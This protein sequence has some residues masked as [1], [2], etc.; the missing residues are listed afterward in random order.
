MNT[1]WQLTD[2]YS[3]PTDPKLEQDWQAADELIKHLVESKGQIGQFDSNALLKLIVSWEA[4]QLNLHRI[5]LYA[6]LLEAT[7]IGIAEVTRFKK[8]VEERLVAKTNQIIFIETELA[9][10]TPKQWATHRAAVEL[11]PYNKLLEMLSKQAQ[12]T[13]SEEAETILSEKGQTSGQALTH[14]YSVTTDTLEFDWDGQIVTLE[15]VMAKFHAS[16]PA[17]RKQ[18]AMVLHSGLLTNK[19]TTPPILNALIQDKAIDDRLRHYEYPEQARLMNDDVERPAVES[20][21]QAVGQSYNLV[22]R[23]YGLKKKI[24]GLDQLYWWDRYAPLPQAETKIEKETAL[25]MVKDAFTQFSP[26]MAAITDRMVTEKHI[27]WLPS[28]TKRGGAFCAFGDPKTYPYVL[29]NYTD[30]PRD[31]M[32]LA[33]E[34]GHAIHDVLASEQNV[35]VQ[36]HPSLAL[37]EIA[38][39]FGETLLFEKLMQSE[40]LTKADKTA[41]LMSFIEDRFA[42]VFRQISMFQFEQALH[43]KR[44]SEGEV[45]REEIDQLWDET[46]RR[47]FES[48][49]TYTPEHAPTWMYVAHIFHWPFYV[50]SYAFAQ[51]C[52][53]ALYKQYKEQGQPFT[54]GYLNLLRAGGSLSPK[55]NLAQ[56]GLDIDQ[57][58]FWKDGLAVLE[59][60]IDDLE[61]LVKD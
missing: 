3:S 26:A 39:V 19:K 29:L 40:N 41:L 23:Y 16:Y 4:L 30:Q 58:A 59:G 7:N 31:A 20:L 37:A 49:M 57:P 12:H 35:F 25:T 46:M 32:T 54:E 1:A 43:E 18:A 27:D 53:L 34:L 6:S 38:S 51:L 42:T 56:L 48:S 44:R 11:K 8:Q 60:F 36:I 22:E 15:E 47:P 17:T 52:V 9:K 5:S 61:T 45:S 13:L 21:T 28:K 14:L 2:L 10:L 24:L 55:D 50:Y 33:H